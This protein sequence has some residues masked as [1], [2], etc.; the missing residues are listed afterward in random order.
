[1]GAQDDGTYRLLQIVT[2]RG[3]PI[4]LT[5][6]HDGKTVMGIPLLDGVNIGDQD[7]RLVLF[8]RLADIEAPKRYETRAVCVVGL[9]DL[10]TH[11]AQLLQNPH[12]ALIKEYETAGLLA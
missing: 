7:N 12:P 11:L 3:T 6:E 4:Q 9:Y 1:M 8:I 2:D 10:L 5:L